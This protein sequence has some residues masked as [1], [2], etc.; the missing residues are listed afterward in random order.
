MEHP[1]HSNDDEIK[2]YL[3][4][5]CQGKSDFDHIELFWKNPVFQTCLGLRKVPSSPTAAV[6][7]IDCNW[8]ETLLQK[9]ADLIRKVKAPVTGHESGEQVV[10]SLDID[11]SPFYNLGTKKEG[12]SLTYKGTLGYAERNMAAHR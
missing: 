4:L 5:L 3:G 12:V 1:L 7:T 9:S 11:V 6:Q 8:S 2:S 10:I